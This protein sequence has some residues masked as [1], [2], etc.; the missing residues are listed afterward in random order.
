MQIQ[1]KIHFLKIEPV[2]QLGKIKENLINH[3][4]FKRDLTSSSLSSYFKH[5]ISHKKLRYE[6]DPLE[7]AEEVT[8]LRAKQ[9]GILVSR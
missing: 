5:K 4:V 1:S 9:E 7:E 2:D 6:N 8:V 3:T